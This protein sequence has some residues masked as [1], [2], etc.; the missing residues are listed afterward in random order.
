MDA[1]PAVQARGLTRTFGEVKAVDGLDLAVTRGEVFGLLG[2]NGAGKT[3]TVRML[4]TLLKPTAGSAQVL[5]LDVE[6]DAAALRRRIGYVPQEITVDAGLTGTENLRFFGRLYGLSGAEIDARG[7]ELLRMFG[8]EGHEDR[9]VRG[10]SGGMK[11]KLDLA[12]G[13]LHR[14]ELLFLDEPSLGLDV[15]TRRAVWDHILELSR[16]GVTILL[17]TNL[18]DEA[19]RLCNRLAIIDRGKLA[20][21]GAPAD[22]KRELGGDVVTMEF[23]TDGARLDALSEALRRLPMVS[24]TMREGDRLHVYVESNETAIPALVDAARGQGVDVRSLSYV[25]PAL[26]EVF[27]RHTGHRFANE[28]VAPRK[29]RG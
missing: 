19:D 3:T 28:P 8:L 6:R 4:V 5:G 18:M 22:L 2:P 26:D 21:L 15:G 16:Q 10:Y 1:G 17:C 25:R 14:P 13:L 20:A 24:S 29:G 9:R 12:C 7:R 23:A 27:L 11:K